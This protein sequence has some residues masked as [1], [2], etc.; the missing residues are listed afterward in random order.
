MVDQ[1]CYTGAETS[2]RLCCEMRSGL[3][4]L[5]N[6]YHKSYRGTDIAESLQGPVASGPT[7]SAAIGH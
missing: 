2:S 1:M 6:I 5:D 3:C 4:R 7:Q